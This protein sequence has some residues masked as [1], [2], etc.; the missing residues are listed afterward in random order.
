MSI[1]RGR[2][3]YLV[4]DLGDPAVARRLRM[5]QAGGATAVLAGFTR[6][7]EPPVGSAPLVL[8]RT[9]DARLVARALSVADVALRRLDSLAGAFEGVD[10]ILARNL[11]M[12]VIGA[13]LARRLTPRPRLIYECL[14]IHRLLVAPGPT[15]QA[16]RAL[17]AGLLARTDLVITSSPAF[18]SAHFDRLS[19]PPPVLLVENK[20]LP[21]TA[22]LPT[23][24]VPS[25]PDQEGPSGS[26][27]VADR[28]A[29]RRSAAGGP[30]RIGWFGALRCARSLDILI[31]AA[32][33]LDGRLEV[34]LRGRPSTAAIPDFHARVAA[35]PHVTF[36][37]PYRN[38]DD[39]A[40][41]YAAV[42]FAWA[43]DFYEAGQNSAWLLPNRLYES[44][45]HGALPMAVN[46]TETAAFLARHG[47]GITL[48]EPLSQTL[49]GCL[50]ALDTVA[51]ARL[52]EAHASLPVETWRTDL[53]EC[54]DLVASV[55]GA[56]KTIQDRPTMATTAV[57]PDTGT[58][59]VVPTLNE[60]AMIESVITALLDGSEPDETCLVVAD[61]GSTDG[62]QAIV[63]GLARRDDRIH[64]IQNPDRIQSAAVNRAVAL[65]GAGRR[66]LVRADAHAGY[67][68][69]YLA[70][71]IEE[72]EATG[73]S[74]VT[75]AMDTRAEGAF[76]CGVAAAQNS[77][78]GNG[79]SAHRR[80]GRSGWVDHGHHALMRLDAF[81]AIGGYDESFSHNE[82]AELDLR[83]A[84]AGGRIWLTAKTAIR[85][86]PRTTVTGLW[87]QYR[88]YGRGRAATLLKH[89]RRPRLRQVLP[90]SVAP[91]LA[92]AFAAF[93]V[94][95]FG[96]P[97]LGLAMALPAGIWALTCLAY[98]AALALRR[99]QSAVA[100]AGP[101][102]MIMHA[103]WSLGFL[104][105]LASRLGA[106]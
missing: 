73:A 10:A 98:A 13:A 92:L 23:A 81:T 39:L 70:T 26:A 54:E 67:P 90:L 4:H 93:P 18:V 96:W 40:A 55:L 72:A 61:G 102:G 37:G 64:L 24:C 45:L 34:I 76:G 95:A 66:W 2:I 33:R 80:P 47:I 3:G 21:E 32:A 5:V 6:G 69:R 25:V 14:D 20:V 105:H 89:A 8:G 60:A 85:Y 97:A 87:R 91:A 35:A 15:G 75:V 30:W 51:Y 49:I 104:T 44:G 22:P 9:N 100:W 50:D 86:H 78:L 48:D 58:L 19:R 84:A 53:S 42:D 68:P 94:G 38:P 36:E 46:G 71:L 88:G 12:L 31:N 52:A 101:A 56:E 79:G 28:G 77:P 106:R 65:L 82:D 43:I 74:A 11:E 62:T 29:P 7:G 57:T 99:Q 103:A 1:G 16:L 27:E 17:E 63:E 83:L 59:V 41:I